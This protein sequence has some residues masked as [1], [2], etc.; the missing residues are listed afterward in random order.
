MNSK[1]GLV[2]RQCGEADY[3]RWEEFV[4]AQPQATFFHQAGWRDIIG[5]AVGHDTYYLYAER[6]GEIAGILPLAYVR[7][8]LFGNTLSSLP[9]CS[10]GG[11]VA[12]DEAARRAL[13]EEAVRIARRLGVGALELR[14]AEGTGAERPVKRLYD[15]FSKPI[16]AS[17]AQN[18]QAIRGKQRNVVRKGL[19][20][21]LTFRDERLEVFY[22][23]YA[24]S[25]RN[26]GTPVFPKALIAA[27]RE[28]FPQN[29]EFVSAC[30]GDEPVSSAMLFYFRDTVCPYYWGGTTKARAVAGNDFLCWQILCRGAERG[31]KTFDFGRSKQGTGPYQWK[32]NWGFTPRPLSYEY[33]LIKAE[34][35]PEIN[36]LNPKYRMFIELWK[37]LP[38][39]VTLVLGPWLSRSLG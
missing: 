3:P 20:S 8:R 28:R 34:R 29:T 10:Y 6:D 7:S 19:K 21:G 12:V 39:P 18:M 22:R 36:P 4:G 30:L 11:A 23:V 38:L 15:T 35:M 37:R 24:E 33:E 2:V 5:R 27:I 13:E 17:E 32:L 14:Y 1:D 25:V 9:F 16:A 31:C 26:L